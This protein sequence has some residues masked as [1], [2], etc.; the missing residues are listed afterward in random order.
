M[1]NFI[2][3]FENHKKYDAFVSLNGI[4]RP[5]VSHCVKENEV[6]YNPV[7]LIFNGHEYVDLGLPSGTLWA[8]NALPMKYQWGSTVAS[9]SSPCQFMDDSDFTKYNENDGLVFLEPSDDAASVNMGGKWH[10]PNRSQI[11][12]LVEN[13]ELVSSKTQIYSVTLVSKINGNEIVLP[14]EN[15]TSWNYYLSNEVASYYN[16]KYTLHIDRRDG[17]REEYELKPIYRCSEAD[18]VA[19]CNAIGVVGDINEIIYINGVLEGSDRS[20]QESE[21][22]VEL[23]SSIEDE[24]VSMEMEV[25][26]DS[27]SLTSNVSTNDNKIFVGTFANP[28]SFNGLSISL[29]ITTNNETLNF[30]GH[31]RGYK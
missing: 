8:K 7:D 9:Q 27:P 6:H 4:N 11:E 17:Y 26:G 15:N 22:I 24:I 21:F 16:D 23:K 30:T 14:S 10:L 1:G 3:L 13:T 20:G 5:N 19:M 12:E 2:K 31:L 29:K 28:I 25:F 18:P